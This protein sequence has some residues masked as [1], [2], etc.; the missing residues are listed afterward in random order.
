MEKSSIDL[1]SYWACALI[2]G[3]YSG[4]EADEAAR[5]R[6]AESDQRSEGWSIVDVGELRFTW[7]YALYD[8]GAGCAGGEVAEYTILRPMVNG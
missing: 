8:A 6:K 4:L 3:D 5:C 1:P 2:N 7:S